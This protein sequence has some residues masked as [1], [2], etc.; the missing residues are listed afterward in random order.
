MK[1]PSSSAHI[2]I[3]DHSNHTQLAQKCATRKWR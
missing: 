2:Y 1:I 3:L